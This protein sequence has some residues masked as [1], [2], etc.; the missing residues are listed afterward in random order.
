MKIKWVK[1]MAKE[2]ISL[3]H[4]S[5]KKMFKKVAVAGLDSGIMAEEG[6]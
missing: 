5:L 3:F 1:K 4:M 6:K 2:G